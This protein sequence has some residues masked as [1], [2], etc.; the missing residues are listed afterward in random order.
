M[1]ENK[2]SYSF[3]HCKLKEHQTWFMSLSPQEKFDFKQNK[4]L[5]MFKAKY[6]VIT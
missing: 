5:I 4:S 6:T 1:Q 2:L 3:A